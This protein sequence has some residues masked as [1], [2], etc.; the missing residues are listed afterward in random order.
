MTVR[1]LLYVEEKFSLER[2][3]IEAE[4]QQ[5]ISGVHIN[6]ENQIEID[7]NTEHT[8]THTKRTNN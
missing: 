2:H 4:K 1:W 3:S 5:L 8:H 6:Q 7:V